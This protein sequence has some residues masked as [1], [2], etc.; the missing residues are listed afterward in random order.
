MIREL[1]KEDIP[2]VSE[3]W[4][5]ASIVAHSFI[6]EDFWRSRL[7]E[8]Q[9][10]YLPN[11]SGY[12]HESDKHIDGFAVWQDC[13]IHCLFVDPIKQ[14][15]GIGTMLLNEIQR[16]H[17]CLCLRV[18][19]QNIGATRFYERHGFVVTK[20][21]ACSHTGFPESEMEWKKNPNNG[22]ESPGAPPAAGTPETHP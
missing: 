20:Q 1:R 12:V 8:M 14:N 9:E 16:D 17:E 13:F 5:Q 6:P 18:Y 10:V 15:K 7:S 19:R 22:L 11:A 3:I 21:T 2:R 4:L